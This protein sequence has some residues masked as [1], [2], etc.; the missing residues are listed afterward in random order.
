MSEKEEI[1]GS[2]IPEILDVDDLAALLRVSR[3]RARDYIREGKV[4]AY[5]IA[6]GRYLISVRK[7]VKVI[8]ERGR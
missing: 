4:P 6:K 8:E 7:L 5:R 3:E 1:K 2:Y